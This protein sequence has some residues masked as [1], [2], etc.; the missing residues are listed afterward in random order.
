MQMI[1]HTAVKT[2][3]FL[4]LLTKVTDLTSKVTG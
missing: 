4:L 3:R 1:K 2:V